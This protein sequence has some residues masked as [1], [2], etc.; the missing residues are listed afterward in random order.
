MDSHSIGARKA[1]MIA[2]QNADILV[3]NGG[4]NGTI[5]PIKCWILFAGNSAGPRQVVTII[6]YVDTVERDCRR[7]GSGGT[8]PFL[9]CH[10]HEHDDRQPKSR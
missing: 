9:Q 10:S 2:I 7:D 5:G 4:T 8:R 3:C 1:D 6:S